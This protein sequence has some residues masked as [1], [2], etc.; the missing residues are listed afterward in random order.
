MINV[1]W[2][3]CNHT[4]YLFNESA[5][6]NHA[7]VVIL[8]MYFFAVTYLVSTS[9]ESSSASST[10]YSQTFRLKV[11]CQVLTAHIGL[12]TPFVTAYMTFPGPC[13]ALTRVCAYS[14]IYHRNMQGCHCKN[15]WVTSTI[16]QSSQLHA[17]CGTLQTSKGCFQFESKL[18]LNQSSGVDK[19][20]PFVELITSS[21]LLINPTKSLLLIISRSHTKTQLSI[22]INTTLLPSVKYL[23]VT[24]TSNLKWNTHITNTC[25]SA[26]Q[27]L[28]LLYCN[29]QLTNQKTLSQLYMQGL[30]PP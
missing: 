15:T 28:G 12:A 19:L 22:T 14:T 25:K 10:T 27:K 30:G 2:N 5:V 7:L 26:K 16:F 21:G 24:I 20:L 4:T 29:F 9:Q 1:F 11:T 23:G 3:F 8:T 18:N 6:I 13:M 17:V